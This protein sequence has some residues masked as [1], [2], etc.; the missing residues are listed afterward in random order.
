MAYY[1]KGITENYFVIVEQPLSVSLYGLIR[2]ALANEP[3]A[4]S[5]Q[6]FPNYEVFITYTKLVKSTARYLLGKDRIKSTAYPNIVS[7]PMS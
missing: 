7:L 2:G 4:K 3:L 5:L 1:F 6:W